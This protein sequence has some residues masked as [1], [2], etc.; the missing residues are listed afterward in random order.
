MHLFQVMS[1]HN[2]FSTCPHLFVCVRIYL[3][4]CSRR[5]PHF[6]TGSNAEL[7]VRIVPVMKV[8]LNGPSMRRFSAHHQRRILLCLLPGHDRSSLR[9]LEAVQQ[10]RR[11]GSKGTS[12]QTSPGCAFEAKDLSTAGSVNQEQRLVVFILRHHH[13]V[14]RCLILLPLLFTRLHADVC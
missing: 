13:D 4:A 9:H 3:N 1:V 14:S 11:M 5:L 12:G 6:F 2:C 7:R 10:P 8:R